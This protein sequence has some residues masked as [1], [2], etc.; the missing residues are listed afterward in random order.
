MTK[1]E[2][3]TKRLCAN[4]SARYYDLNKTPITCPK[5]GAPF[6]VVA[7]TTQKRFG[8]RAIVSQPEVE[9]KEAPSESELISEGAGTED[10]ETDETAK[11][12]PED[13]LIG[14]VEEEVTD[15]SEIIGGD[16]KNE[17][18]I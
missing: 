14:E 3:G 6:E 8:Q 18:D 17:E 15:V 13:T 5:C 10:V 11:D 9:P 2:L 16:D 7:T 12:D 1:A 4:C